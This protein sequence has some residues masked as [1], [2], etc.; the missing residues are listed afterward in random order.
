MMGDGTSPRR[1]FLLG[2]LGAPG[3]GSGDPCSAGRVMTAA[4]SYQGRGTVRLLTFVLV[5]ER[6]IRAL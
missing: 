3:R 2:I 5:L 4:T 1:S 6:L